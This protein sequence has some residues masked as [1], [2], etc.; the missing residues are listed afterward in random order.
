MFYENRST[1]SKTKTGD[2]HFRQGGDLGGQSH[3]NVK[4]ASV[5]PGGNV[6]KDLG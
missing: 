4:L 2:K 6:L 5:K 1:Y 3:R